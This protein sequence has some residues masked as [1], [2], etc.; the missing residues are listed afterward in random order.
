M[1]AVQ[2]FLEQRC[3]DCALTVALQSAEKGF[4]YN[5]CTG[6]S[7]W[8]PPDA[9]G[10]PSPEGGR[11]WIVDGNPTWDAPAEYAWRQV[12]STDAAHE[13]RV[14]FENYN[15]GETTWERPPAL[16]WS[17]RS[18]NK[19][20]FYNT[21]TGQSVA[22]APAHAV[23]METPD[24]TKY[25]TDP[26]TGATTWTKPVAAAWVEAKEDEKTYYF[27]EHTQERA[28]EK[29]ADSNLAWIRMHEEL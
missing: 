19:T 26:V 1:L 4:W 24:G 27:N 14:Y 2:R 20:Y 29:P 23:G 9:L 16:G 6:E 18:Y 5:N 22:T 15:T 21:V 7:S 8:T 12:V 17:R 10:I 3:L 11:Y 25:Y 28:W 13:G